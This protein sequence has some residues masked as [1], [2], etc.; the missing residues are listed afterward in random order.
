MLHDFRFALRQLLKAR[1]FTVAA[2]TVLAFGIG[3]NTAIFSLLDTT[4][5]QPPAFAKPTETWLPA[6]RAT[7]IS[8]MVALRTE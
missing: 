4:L 6:R 3:A 2:V 1:G 8:P 5:F 7:R